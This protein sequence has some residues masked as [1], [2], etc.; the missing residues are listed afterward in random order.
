MNIF[1][2]QLLTSFLIGGFVVAG[3]GFFAER[4]PRSISGV[5]L[6]LPSTVLISYLFIGWTIGVDALAMAIPAT[7]ASAASPLFFAYAY[8]HISKRVSHKLI[9][10]VLSF[11]G[12]ITVWLAISIPPAIYK[13]QH[14]IPAILV[15]IILL[16]IAHALLTAR[17]P[18]NTT[19]Q[20]RQ[21][22]AYQLL[23]RSIFAGFIIA[24]SVFLAKMVNPFW[25]AVFSGFPAVYSST[26]LIFH[27]YYVPDMIARVSKNLPKGS[28]VYVAFIIASFWTFPAFGL[29][30]GT[31]AAYVASG[32][33][34]LFVYKFSST[35]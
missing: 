3:L 33:T 5:V 19:I 20:L 24:S 9:S 10:M 27:W 31:V 22:T 14:M 34:F 13:A 12:A 7:V 26:L 15:F 25:G 16:L 11:A 23:G 1:Y 29:L 30:L 17:A 21:Y 6:S 35:I 28:V 4:L 2:I 8:L 32:V 18:A